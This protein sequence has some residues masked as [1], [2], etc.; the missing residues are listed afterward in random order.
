MWI[1]SRPYLWN[2]S[3][4]P[5]NCSVLGYYATISGNFSQ[6][7]RDNLFVPS[8]SLKVLLKIGPIS[9]PET[10][11]RNYP[12]S[13]SYSPEQRSS[14]LVCCGSMRSR[15][16]YLLHSRKYSEFRVRVNLVIGSYSQY[17]DSWN[18]SWDRNPVKV[19]RR[20]LI[21]NAGPQFSYDYA[22]S[23]GSL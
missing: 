21:W 20:N 2:R 10:S 8:P 4:L 19:K 17:M 11:V 18:L 7:F 16:C 14:H 3:L 13:L 5:E 23:I 6:T 1:H 12:Y 15:I 22:C 9:C